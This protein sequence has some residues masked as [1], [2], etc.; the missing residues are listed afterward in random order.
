MLVSHNIYLYLSLTAKIWT[1]IVYLLLGFNVSYV[2]KI[3]LPQIKFIFV[4]LATSKTASSLFIF[5]VDNSMTQRAAQDRNLG[6]IAI[7]LSS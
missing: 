5:S 1:H 7:A 4:T 2:L 6:V 3:N